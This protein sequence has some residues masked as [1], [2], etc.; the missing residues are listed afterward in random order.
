[1]KATL[2]HYVGEDVFD[3]REYLGIV[4]DTPFGETKRLLTANFAPQRNV[5]DEVFVFRQ[6]A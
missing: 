1:M 4:S 5:E 2:I 3:L 6:A